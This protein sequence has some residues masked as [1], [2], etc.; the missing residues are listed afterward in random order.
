MKRKYTLK[1][2]ARQQEKTRARI[3]DA[4]MALHEQLGPRNTTI[5]AVA[6]RAGVQRLT[7]YRHFPDEQALFSA[8]TGHWLE[9]NPPPDPSGWQHLDDAAARTRTALAA[10]GSYYRHTADMWAAAYRDVDEV[11]ALSGPMREFERYLERIRKD[12]LGAWQVQGKAR[13][14]HVTGILA[15]AVRFSTWQSLA[16]E[17]LKDKE[18]AQ[19]LCL[20]VAVAA[21]PSGRPQS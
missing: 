16:G 19:L 6:E 9:L 7:V 17:K 14:R 5:S 4:A 10:L 11:P 21:A 12:L 2:R 8:C 13:R 20:W 15:H 1:K 18:I 3:V